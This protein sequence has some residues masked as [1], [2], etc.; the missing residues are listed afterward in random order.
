MILLTGGKSYIFNVRQSQMH[1]QRTHNAAATFKCKCASLQMQ[2][3]CKLRLLLL[4]DS[5]LHFVFDC[6]APHD[7]NNN[8]DE[9]LWQ[10]WCDCLAQDANTHTHTSPTVAHL[11]YPVDLVSNF[12]FHFSGYAH[13]HA[14]MVASHAKGDKPATR[15][16]LL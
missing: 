6:K 1:V 16:W 3:P 8:N 15:I 5:S 4:L 9:D 2:I 11:I 10:L 14:T 12:L 7:N 13:A